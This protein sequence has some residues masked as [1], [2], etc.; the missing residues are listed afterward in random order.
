MNGGSMDEQTK[1]AM[2]EEEAQLVRGGKAIDAIRQYKVHEGEGSATT[3]PGMDDDTARVIAVIEE[4]A[5][6]A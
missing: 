2:N 6:W 3:Y 4:R 5:M 1:A